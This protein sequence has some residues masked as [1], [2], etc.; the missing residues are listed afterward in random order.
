MLK[1]QKS[2][3]SSKPN[4]AELV[5]IFLFLKVVQKVVKVRLSFFSFPSFSLGLEVRFYVL[6]AM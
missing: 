2:S 5:E 3:W 6:A 4:Y 1:D